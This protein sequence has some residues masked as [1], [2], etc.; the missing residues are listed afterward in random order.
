MINNVKSRRNTIGHSSLIVA[1][2]RLETDFTDAVKDADK[3]TIKDK[4]K[5][6]KEFKQKGRKISRR[7][8][9]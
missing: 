8:R 6:V 2:V 9:V 5:K 3:K 1:Q 4:I 7:S